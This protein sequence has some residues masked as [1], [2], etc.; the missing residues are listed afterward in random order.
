LPGGRRFTA[1]AR[2]A[3]VSIAAL[4]AGRSGRADRSQVIAGAGSAGASRSGGE[5]TRTREHMDAH[6]AAVPPGHMQR[7][8]ELYAEDLA[9]FGYP[10]PGF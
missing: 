9:V 3:V 10:W 2:L 6:Y 4:R 7:L 8:R 1:L 5:A